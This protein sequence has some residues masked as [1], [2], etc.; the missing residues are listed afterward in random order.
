[1][2][3]H[4]TTTY[5][6]YIILIYQQDGYYRSL[7]CDNKDNCDNLIALYTT[8]YEALSYAKKRIDT[9]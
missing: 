5:K 6:N 7:I 4:S 1:M 2:R 9:K 8:C 3:L